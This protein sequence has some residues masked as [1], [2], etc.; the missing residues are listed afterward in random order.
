[1]YDAYNG[2][3]T[4]HFPVVRSHLA[5]PIVTLNGEFLYV[6]C[7]DAGTVAMASTAD[8]KDVGSPISLSQNGPG[9]IIA[10]PNG[11]YLYVLTTNFP[12][13]GAVTVID[14]SE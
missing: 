11:N 12:G 6:S 13:N 2:A 4:A 5:Q 14:I 10:A 7:S 9:V 3:Q 1:V 8:N